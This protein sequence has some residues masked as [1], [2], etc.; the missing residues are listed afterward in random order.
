MDLLGW[1]VFGVLV[2]IL[3]RVVM[4]ESTSGHSLSSLVLGITGGV[5][6]G[7]L[8]RSTG[9]YDGPA[10]IGFL[11]I[12]LLAIVILRSTIRVA[13]RVVGGFLARLLDRVL[14]RQSAPFR[15]GAVR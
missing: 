13:H 15:R 12:V 8:A 4:P 1:I 7:W 2:A 11:L 6:G 9:F 10:P 3:A 5:I 14:A